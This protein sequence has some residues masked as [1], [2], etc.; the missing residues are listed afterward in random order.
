MSTSR[1]AKPHTSHGGKDRRAPAGLSD[2]RGY[3]KALL[4]TPLNFLNSE[5]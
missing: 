2:L 3:A 4:E 5:E 1:D